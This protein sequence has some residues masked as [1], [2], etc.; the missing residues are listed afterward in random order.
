MASENKSAN[1]EKLIKVEVFA[2]QKKARSPAIG[3]EVDKK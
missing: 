2:G 3:L 1:I